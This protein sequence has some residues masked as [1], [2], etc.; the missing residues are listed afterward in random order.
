MSTCEEHETETGNLACTVNVCSG[1]LVLSLSATSWMEIR[2]GAARTDLA[3]RPY[4]SN[5]RMNPPLICLIFDAK[6]NVCCVL[7]FVVVHS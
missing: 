3:G 1:G 7:C 4:V 2:G 5:Q 6:L